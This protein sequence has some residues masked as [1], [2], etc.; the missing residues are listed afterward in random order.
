MENLE[1]RSRV[2]LKAH[3]KIMKMMEEIDEAS[4]MAVINFTFLKLVLM[5][6][7]EPIGAMAMTATF[8][9][10]V[11]NSIHDYHHSAAADDEQIH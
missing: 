11:M 4:A 1:E 9:R 10:N 5:K 7:S 6:T 8:M 3:N 2:I